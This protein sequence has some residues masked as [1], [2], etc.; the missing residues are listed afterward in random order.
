MSDHTP[1]HTHAH[2]YLVNAVTGTALATNSYASESGGMSPGTT[3]NGYTRF[4]K[5]GDY[6]EAFKFSVQWLGGH[7][8]LSS[9]RTGLSIC[10]SHDKTTDKREICQTYSPHSIATIAYDRNMKVGEV[11][12]SL[13]GPRMASSLWEMEEVD[14]GTFTFRNAK[15]QGYLAVRDGTP[16]NDSATQQHL[17]ASQLCH[18]KLI[19]AGVQE[20]SSTPTPGFSLAE[21][22]RDNNYFKLA[23]PRSEDIPMAGATATA[24]IDALGKMIGIFPD[25]NATEELYKA[26]VKAMKQIVR[27]ELVADNITD[28]MGVLNSARLATRVDEASLSDDE[29]KTLLLAAISKYDDCIGALTTSANARPGLPVFNQA[30]TEQ[31]TLFRAIGMIEGEA[32][33]SR[34]TWAE[35]AA[36]Y[37]KHLAQTYEEMLKDRLALITKEGLMEMHFTSHDTY[38]P[39]VNNA[40]RIKV[41]PDHF[42]TMYAWRVQQMSHH[43]NLEC[44]DVARTLSLWDEGLAQAA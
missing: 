18:W 38:Q 24:K 17:E 26:L 31:L 13:P 19:R 30:A 29:L 35:R 33:Y 11:E 22:I 32:A 16:R 4:G 20:L 40:K 12:D 3:I 14:H 9:K 39:S 37:R 7:V 5:P 23:V 34:N 8:E 28:A 1:D 41:D 44:G 6:N 42:D 10:V 21:D 27:E 15:T 2:Y 36:I 43:L 25:Q